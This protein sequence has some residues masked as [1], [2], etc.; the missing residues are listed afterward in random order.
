MG[1]I[2][3]TCIGIFFGLMIGEIIETIKIISSKKGEIFELKERVKELEYIVEK[4][5]IKENYKIY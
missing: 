4:I 1:L 2:D 5:Q 3:G